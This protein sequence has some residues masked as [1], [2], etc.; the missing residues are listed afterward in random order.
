ML[1]LLCAFTTTQ[2][3]NPKHEVEQCIILNPF[4][5]QDSTITDITDIMDKIEAEGLGYTD[6]GLR[7]G[8]IWSEFWTNTDN[9]NPTE[10]C[11]ESV[12]LTQIEEQ[13]SSLKSKVPESVF[14]YPKLQEILARNI[15]PK[16]FTAIK[17][18][19]GHSL[20]AKFFTQFYIQR[21]HTSTPMEWHQ[22]PGEDHDLM[23]LH[24]LVLMLS[25]Q[26]DS[27]HGW[28]GGEFKIRPGLPTDSNPSP[29]QTIIHQYNQAILFN[30]QHNSHSVT[31]VTSDKERSKRDLVVVLLFEQIP[32]LLPSAIQE[33]KKLL[34]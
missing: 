8:L 16:T 5:N 2:P 15:L 33:R 23:A 30:N 19:H 28:K 13:E 21:C 18:K 34:N 20:P 17:K 22:D 4:F 32:K 24:S 9:P 26:D 31:S 3:A 6:Y 10:E 11:K 27:V 14:T 7:T 29:P 12:R 25:N 1:M